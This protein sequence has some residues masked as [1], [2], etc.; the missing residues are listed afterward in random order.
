MG[1]LT[2]VGAAA[3]VPDVARDALPAATVARLSAGE[4]V[5]DFVQQDLVHVI[6]F[7]FG[8]QIP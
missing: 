3:D 7:E 5:R 1:D 4:G 6:I 8:R 2:V